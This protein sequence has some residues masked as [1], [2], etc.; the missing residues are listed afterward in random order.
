MII[1]VRSSEPPQLTDLDR[2]DRLHAERHGALDEVRLD[3]LCRPGDGEHVWLDIGAARET[4]ARTTGDPTFGEQ[5]DAMIAYAR[6]SGW[7]DEA[8]THVRAHLEAVD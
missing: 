8:G 1:V 6:S 2:F 5:F 7:V 3:G 4:G